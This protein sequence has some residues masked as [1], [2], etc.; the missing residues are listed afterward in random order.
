MHVRNRAITRPACR[1]R[2]LLGDVPLAA[3][4]GVARI[5]IVVAGLVSLGAASCAGQGDSTAGAPTASQAA[6]DVVAVETFASLLDDPGVTTINVHVPYEGELPGTDAF[7]P[8]DQ[9]VGSP[10]LPEDRDRP[11]AVYCMSGSMSAQAAR[12]LAEAG[13]SDIRD[14][15]G[16][17]LAWQEAGRDLVVD[18]EA[19][20]RE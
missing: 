15:D 16:G 11:I 10:T 17:L 1:V 12:A 18:D 2:S 3:R 9:V 7:V 5:A 20:S 13:F 14:L 6:I 4:S 19:V 8:Y